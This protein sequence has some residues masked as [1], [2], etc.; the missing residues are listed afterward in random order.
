MKVSVPMLRTLTKTA[1]GRPCDH[2]VIAEQIGAINILAISGGRAF[3]IY[4]GDRDDVVG[5][6]LIIDGTRR[7]DVLLDWSDTYVVRRLRTITKGPKRGTDVV[8]FEQSDV[9]CDEIGEVAYSASCW[10]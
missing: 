4:S 3:P 8:E 5:L 9:Y 7:V 1:E 2:R 6:R 10:K